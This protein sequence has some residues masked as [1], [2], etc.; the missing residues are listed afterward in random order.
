[1]IDEAATDGRPF[2]GYLAFTAPHWPLHALPED[3]ERYRSR[4][5]DGWDRLRTDRHEAALGAGLLSRRWPISPKDSGAPNWESVDPGLREWEALRMSVYAAQIDRMDQ[6]IGAVLDRLETSGLGENT[7][8]VFL[9]D[10]GGCAEFLREGGPFTERYTL[11][12]GDGRTTR[13]GNIPRL[14]PGPADTF[15]S[16]DLPWANA[17]NSPFRLFKCWTHEGGVSTPLILSGPGLAPGLAGTVNHDTV[18]LVDLAATFLDLADARP[19]RPGSAPP[20]AGETLRPAMEGRSLSRTRPIFWEHEGNCA[21]R[22]GDLKLVRRRDAAWELY[23]MDADRTEL[24]DLS[25]T[26]PAD[27]ARLIAR[28]EEMAAELAVLPWETIRQRRADAASRA[29]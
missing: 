21:L 14:E 17:S 13:V 27:R 20:L 8:V 6:A 11:P 19:A 7:V 29:R 28:W 3:I 5:R 23:R 2:F 16:Y 10:N 12:V 22:D 4:Y 18:H 1:M 26:L 9:S 24:S 25:A 15:M